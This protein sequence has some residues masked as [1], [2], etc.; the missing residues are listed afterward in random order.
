MNI[1]VL[2]PNPIEA[3][4]MQCDKHVVKMILETAQLLCSIYEPGT[5]PYKRTHYN[6]PCAIWTRESMDN[7]YWLV[8]HGFALCK[9]YTF[10]YN[11]THKSYHVIEWCSKL[12]NLC[13]NK[14]E[15]QSVGQTPFPKCMPDDCKSNDVVQSY[16]KYYREHKK[17]IAKWTKRMQPMWW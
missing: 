4:K 13:D 8:E 9:E 14:I 2:D 11:K 12:Q 15:F 17:D 1:F 6:H 10:R 7:Y 3:A 16:R 5:A